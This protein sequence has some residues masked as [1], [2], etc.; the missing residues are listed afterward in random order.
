MKDEHLAPILYA[1]TLRARG[2]DKRAAWLSRGFRR[3]SKPAL[4]VYWQARIAS[5][6]QDLA[7]AQE[8]HSEYLAAL[9]ARPVP[10]IT[11]QARNLAGAMIAEGKA[12]LTGKEP[13]SDEEIA[14][15]LAICKAP[16][17][18]LA[19]DPEGNPRCAECGCYVKRK[20]RWRSQSCPL[21]KW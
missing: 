7:L 11:T 1:L 16:C 14:R 12:I 10:G 19:G 9:K 17:A 6:E 13:V 8:V 15:R 18:K 4:L 3:I 20:T 2:Q 21:G 5:N